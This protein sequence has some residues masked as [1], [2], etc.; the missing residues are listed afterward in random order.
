MSA[1]DAELIRQATRG[2]RD[3][4]GTLL[5]RV[6]PAVRERFRNEIP[7]R[8]QSL[9]TLD[10][11]MQ[12]TYTDAFLDIVEFVPR[13]NGSFERWLA[14]IARHNLLNA[15]EMLEAE[16]RGGGRRA[17]DTQNIEQSFIGLHELVTGTSTSPSGCAAR[18]D[19]RE[20]L[21]IAMRKLPEDY[22]RVVEMYDLEGRPIDELA[23]AFNR[24]PGALYMLRARAHR[25]LRKHLGAASKYLSDSA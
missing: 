15:L 10:D 25:A 22:R 24:R 12:E 4:L 19:A 11:L 6:G 18:T 23:K 21:E 8:W 14:T 17:I 1:T 16:K 20:A 3:S 2:C 7:R 5:A 13:G 9:L